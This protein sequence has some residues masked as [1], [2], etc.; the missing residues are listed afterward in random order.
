MIIDV[1]NEILDTFKLMN[2]EFL[3][4]PDYYDDVSGRQEYRLYSYLTTFFN[5]I[6]I[7]DIGTFD[8]RSAVSLSHNQTNKVISY[9]IENKINNDNHI[10][11]SKSNIQFKVKNVLEDL[12]EDLVKQCKIVLI[13]IDHYETIEKQLINR[14]KE[15]NYS[16]LIL[17]DDITNHP[18]PIINKCMN[19]LWDSI[20]ELKFDFTKYG[21]FSGTGVIV[22]NDE[23]SFDYKDDL[24]SY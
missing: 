15:L 10:I 24:I 16:G 21:H 19:R 3:V 13:D 17:L 5:N 11:Y 7:L 18:E 4:N 8:G 14:L 1:S 23:I 6:T 2:H 22:M 9:D 20:D 12:T